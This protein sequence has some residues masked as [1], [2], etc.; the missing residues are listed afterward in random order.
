M[1]SKP[2]YELL[3]IMSLS[4][5]DFKTS[6]TSLEFEVPYKILSLL[7]TICSFDLWFCCKVS[8]VVGVQPLDILLDITLFKDST[9]VVL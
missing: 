6:E 1:F 7:S 8:L 5:K 4:F 2:F 3:E 9:A